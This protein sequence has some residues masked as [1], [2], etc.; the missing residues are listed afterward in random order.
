MNKIKIINQTN[1][2]EIISQLKQTK[3]FVST[4]KKGEEV[5]TESSLT[6]NPI[7]FVHP[8]NK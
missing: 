6:I 3:A 4:R 2:N 1:S 7:S 5:L 8:D